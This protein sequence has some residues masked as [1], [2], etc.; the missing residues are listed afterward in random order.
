MS[1][2]KK[3]L[4]DGIE[5][6][7]DGAMT[8]IQACEAAGIEV[9]RFCYHERLSIAGNCRMC[10]VE[11]VGG[12]PKPAA[13]CAMQVR[14]L[15]GGPN[16]EPA[17]VKTNSPMVKKAREGVMEFL[18][19][20][21]PLD[22]PICDQGGECD[23][24]DQ[25]MAY[26]VDFSRYREPKRASEN[27]NLGPLVKTEMTRCISCT[28]CVRFTTEVAGIHQMGQ[29]G[30]GE[31]SEITSYLNETLA[32]N[33][34]GNI[35]DLC[36]VGALT[37]KP[38]AF[39]ARPWELTKTESIDVM[40]ALGS[41]IRIDAKGR[42]VM[43][44]LP[45][46]HDGVNEE[47][48][49]DKSRF[50]WDGL[51]RQRLDTPYIR[52]NGKLRKATWPEALAAAA[53]AMTGAK[54]LAGLVGDLAPVEAA[55]SLKSLVES[56][57]GSVESRTDGARLPAGNRS[58]YVGNATIAD[59]DGAKAV[60]I[61]G[62]NPRVE[63]PVLNARIRKA[64]L[65]GAVVSLIGEAV[66]LTYDYTHAGTDRA[67]LASAGT[68]ETGGVVIVGQNA[69]SEADGEAVL[70][71]AMALASRIG[72]KL[73]VLHTAAARVGALDVGAVT[74]GGLIAATEGA[75]VIYNLG[76][77]EVEIGSGAFVI[78]QGSHGDRGANRADVI[79]PGAAYT[80]E[81]GLFVNTEGRPQLAMRAGFAPGEAK[82]NWAVLRALSAEVG[83]QL[84]WD[85]LAQL[86]SRIVAAHP[87]LGAVDQVADNGWTP[88]TR[89]D[90]GAAS[91]RLARGSFYLTNPIARASTTMG[92]LAAQE[93]ARDTRLA[94][95]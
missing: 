47:W 37:S 21:H 54:K 89:M 2:L 35:I 76:A 94:A 24:Q 18:L 69:I 7:V 59:I 13:S 30:R 90:M 80:E 53:K 20:N 31:D 71:N 83:K 95:E 78:Y 6:E 66:D 39:T 65:K 9:P 93:A 45:R 55:Y 82:E 3:V 57:G 32:S 42:E 28:R 88:L 40:D 63:A 34:Q 61:V 38:Y 79:L 23:L 70:A 74:E 72:G 29:T 49:S 1:N 50:I 27:L 12:P 41:N 26:G 15:R 91:F 56:L 22:C 64:W 25:A 11:V 67:A 51:R 86:R 33:L 43:R 16:G 87:H 8:I 36:P 81:N 75:D 44:I 14:D 68:A 46:N 17:V 60:W 58:A 62:S 4:I 5:V 84:P 10:L 19:I 48:I 52:E 73:L 85:S 77:D 92:E